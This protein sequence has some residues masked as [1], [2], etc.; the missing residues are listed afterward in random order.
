MSGGKPWSRQRGE[1]QAYNYFLS[2]FH[3]RRSYHGFSELG[4]QLTNLFPT[5][6]NRFT[7]GPIEPDF[8]LY[9][10]ST[11]ILAEVK[12]GNN[13]EP[14]DAD[15]VERL[16]SVS[17]DAAEEYLKNVAVEDRF[18][19]GGDVFS[20]EPLIY[21]DGLTGTYVERCRNEWENC[22]KQLEAVESNCPVLGREGNRK[23]KLLAGGFD[24]DNL[25]DWME[26]GIEMAE[27]PRVTV[28]MTDSLE[29]ESIAVTL[30]RVWGERAVAAPVSV[31][32]T[33]MRN[34]FN[35][36]ELEPQRVQSAF[37]LLEELGAC[38]R[39]GKRE[40]EFTPEHMPEILGIGE[41][42]NSG[43]GGQQGDLDEFF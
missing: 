36:R 15:Q 13:I 35:Y 27:T 1:I 37:K 10:G 4:Y 30:C 40:I 14:R 21:Y 43:S 28:S 41:L 32:V 22:R 24:S 9:D 34:H 23:L 38:N 7:N 42:I 33:E 3:S 5:I 16:A 29:I 25:T 26:Y 6:D 39:K 8:S 11:L 31:G 19:F 12:Q 2:T 20:V 17:I 18:G